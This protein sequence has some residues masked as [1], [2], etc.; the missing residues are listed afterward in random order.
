M[1]K[2]IYIHLLGYEVD[3]GHMEALRL[4]SST[5]YQEKQIVRQSTAK[6]ETVLMAKRIVAGLY[7][8]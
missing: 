5:E 3:F 8:A 1:A 7:G 6:L 2:L 4:L